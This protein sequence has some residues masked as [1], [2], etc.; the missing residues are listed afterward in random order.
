MIGL[1]PKTPKKERKPPIRLKPYPYD[2]LKEIRALADLLPGGCVDLSAGNPT[3]SPPE[4]ALERLR[5]AEGASGYPQ[6]AGSPELTASAVDWLRRRFGVCG[7][8]G[9]SEQARNA[10]ACVGMKE[11]V[12]SLPRLL[13]MRFPDRDTVLYPAVSYPTYAMGAELA[14]LRGLP[15]PMNDEWRLDLAAVSAEDARRALCLWVNSPSN[16]TGALDDLRSAAAWGRERGVPVLSD[17]CYVEFIWQ[18]P[19]SG[20]S[21]LEQGSEGVL[22]VH[23]LSKR[24]NFA[25]MRV[26]FYAGDEELVGYLSEARRH[27]GLMVPGPVQAAAAA[28]WGDDAHVEAQR[29]RYLRRLGLLKRLLESFGLRV[30]LPA[31]GFY[32][33]VAAPGGDAWG[34]TRRLAEEAG[35]LVTPGDFFGEAGSGHVRVAAVAQDAGIELALERL[36]A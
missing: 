25:G 23:S 22:A 18:T 31:G 33:W 21:I 3:D 36:G 10:A 5:A 35:V 34:L 11:F 14:G 32:L 24:S 9:A 26:G 28:A 12:G 6:S 30:S 2:K 19:P 29:G 20:R 1:K 27:L 7:A 16:P 13:A 17:E 15:I 4:A 8:L